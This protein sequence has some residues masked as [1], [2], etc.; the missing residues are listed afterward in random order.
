MTDE[1]QPPY[2]CKDCGAERQLHGG[3]HR[4]VRKWGWWHYTCGRKWHPEHGWGT[5]LATR[6]RQDQLEKL[7]G[8]VRPAI[9]VL[10]DTLKAA[11]L[12]AGVTVAKNLLKD[13]NEVMREDKR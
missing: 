4:Q 12:D 11:R 8:R 3:H 2:E 5:R 10:H 6:C 13:L 7:L 9:R 1:K